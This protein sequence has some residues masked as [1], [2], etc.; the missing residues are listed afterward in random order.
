[1]VEVNM[2]AVLRLLQAE[3]KNEGGM[4]AHATVETGDETTE[5]GAGESYRCEVLGLAAAADVRSLVPACDIDA[6]AKAEEDPGF[7]VYNRLSPRDVQEY[8]GDDGG[9]RC[10][11]AA[12]TRGEATREKCGSSALVAAEGARGGDA[13]RRGWR[14]TGVDVLLLLSAL[15]ST[16]RV[17]GV[18]A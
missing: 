2:K 16:R 12:D 6:R 4:K 18:D 11:S 3:G 8:E 15:R 17:L 1:L 7:C 10:I 14:R 13:R 9:R 5:W